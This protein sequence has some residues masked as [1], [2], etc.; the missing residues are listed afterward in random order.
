MP[1]R[2]LLD[3]SPKKTH[4]RRTS[5]SALFLIMTRNP[6]QEAVRMKIETPNRPSAL[7]PLAMSCAAL[8]MFLSHLLI[9]GVVHEADERT[10]AHI[11]QILMAGQYR[12]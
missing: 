5:R 1:Y 9:V 8:A 2:S 7:L 10:A 12:S 4:T 3:G 6:L 11:F